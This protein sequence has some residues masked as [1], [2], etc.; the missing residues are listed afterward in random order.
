MILLYFK[1]LIIYIMLSNSALVFFLPLTYQWIAGNSNNFLQHQ[2]IYIFI[3]TP[4][5][6]KGE[7]V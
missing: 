4:A 6:K 3:Y 1:S 7:A 2:G 5:N